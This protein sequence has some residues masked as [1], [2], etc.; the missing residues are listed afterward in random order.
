MEKCALEADIRALLGLDRDEDEYGAQ[1]GEVASLSRWYRGF[2]LLGVGALTH[3][4]QSGPPARE[5]QCYLLLLLGSTLFVDKSKDRVSAVVNLFVKRPDML[6]E[7]AWGA[8]ALAYLYRQLGIASRSV[9]AMRAGAGQAGA[10]WW[11][12]TAPRSSKKR[13]AQMLAYYRHA[14]DSLTPQ[15]VSWTPYG[16]SPHLTVRCTLYQGLLRF[17]EIAEY[18]D[19]T[20]C[21]RQLGYVPGVPYPPDRPLVVRR[22][23]STLGYSLSY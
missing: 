12:G 3:L 20:R 17:A 5:A 4:Q 15:S 18:Y 23:A 2:G 7:Y 9:G 8:G 10:F 22:P 14:I 16:H 6:G 13:D 11:R 21:L 19:P 1:V